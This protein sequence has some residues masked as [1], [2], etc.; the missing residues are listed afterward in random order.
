MDKFSSP[1]QLNDYVKVANASVWMILLSIIILL[2]GICVWGVFG[3]LD[4]TLTVP[5]VSKGGITVCYVSEAEA[6]NIEAGM[7]VMIGNNEYQVSKVSSSPVQVTEDFEAYALH[8]GNLTMGEWVYEIEISKTL[9]DGVYEA[10][11][12]TERIAPMSFLLN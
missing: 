3:R 8:I 11:I 12:I 5:A 10:K 4:T 7:P 2:I 6:G 9:S 1:E